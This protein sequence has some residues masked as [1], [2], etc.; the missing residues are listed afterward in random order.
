MAYEATGS[1]IRRVFD[2]ALSP[3]FAHFVQQVSREE[4]DLLKS[5]LA[6]LEKKGRN[7][8]GK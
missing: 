5:E 2:G 1:F 3:F 7:Q 4:L 6:R 8:R